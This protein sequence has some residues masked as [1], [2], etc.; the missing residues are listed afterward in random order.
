MPEAT[1]EGQVRRPCSFIRIVLCVLLYNKRFRE[2]F[3][4]R[5]SAIMMFCSE[6]NV[7][8]RSSLRRYPYR[9]HLYCYPLL[10]PIRWF[11]DKIKKTTIFLNMDKDMDGTPM[12]VD[13][14]SILRSNSSKK[15]E[16]NDERNNGLVILLRGPIRAVNQINQQTDSGNFLLKINSIKEI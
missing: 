15:K 14:N 7:D 10:K 12:D 9:Y 11:S 3:C 16:T 5:L 2:W 13:S 8:I 6:W 1:N 4:W